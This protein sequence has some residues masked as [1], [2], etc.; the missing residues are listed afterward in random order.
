MTSMEGDTSLQTRGDRDK[1]AGPSL[2]A[3]DD[4]P[5]FLGTTDIF[6][7]VILSVG[8]AEAKDLLHFCRISILTLQKPFSTSGS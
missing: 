2:V 6:K 3:Q 5:Y 8:V 4:N 1:K 7:P